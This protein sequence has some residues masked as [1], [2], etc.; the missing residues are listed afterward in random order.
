[1]TR[2]I[3][4]ILNAGSGSGNDDAVVS[5]LRT[6]FETAGASVD[7]RFVRH[8]AQLA[9]Q[10]EAAKAEQPDVIVAGG[11]DGT[12]SAVAASLVGSEIALGVLALGTLNHFAKDL[13]VPLDVARAVHCIAAGEA[14]RVDVG[15][16][17]GRVFVNNSSLGLYPDIVRDRERQQKRLGRGK[18]AAMG[19]AVLA[20][21]RRY[22]F[23]R[24]TLRVAG[25]ERQVRTPFVFIGNN[26]YRMEG[27]SIGERSH[28]DQGTLSLYFAQRPGRLRLLQFALRALFGKLRQARDFE[29][30]LTPDLVVES[31][32]RKLR[33]ATDGEIAMM[34]PP[35]RYRSRPASLRVMRAEAGT[36]SPA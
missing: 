2:R 19:W 14:V 26:E 30:L 16:V 27:L 18:L 10:V 13:G 4:V 33:V 1:M 21:L 15:E 7:I 35:L 3:V 25:R 31:R 29:V 12:V 9:A 32:H 22:S 36:A 11:G 17:N 24:V 6:L 23:M 5:R 34:T 8:G 28:L 20:V